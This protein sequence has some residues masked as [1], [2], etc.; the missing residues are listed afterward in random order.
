MQIV[1]DLGHQ[2]PRATTV[3]QAPRVCSPRRYTVSPHVA[4]SGDYTDPYAPTIT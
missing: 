1:L 4:Q 2:S 3:A